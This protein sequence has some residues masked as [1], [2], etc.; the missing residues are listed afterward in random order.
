MTPRLPLL[1]LIMAG[2]ELSAT[3]HPA[4]GV[5]SLTNDKVTYERSKT[6]YAILKRGEVTAIIVDNRAHELP[7]QDLPSHRPGY[8][9]VSSLT[10]E[11]GKHNLFVPFFAG[12]NFEHIHDGTTANLKNKFE[13]RIFPM[14][15]RLVDEHTVELYQAPT[16]HWSLE[17]C[18]R[19]HLLADGTIEY[20]FECIPREAKY[21]RKFIGLFWAS[22]IQ[23]PESGSIHFLGQHLHGKPSLSPA[24]ITATSPAHGT[25]STHPP[26]A[27][28][29]A[30][31][32]IDRDFPLTLVNHPS[33]YYYREPFYFGVSGN[34]AFVQVFRSS[35]QIWF[36][37]SPSGG[38]HGNPAW[39]F[40]WFIRNPRVHTAYGFV[41][42]A[43]YL[44]F[45]SRE[46]VA[47]AME[48][49]LRAL[50]P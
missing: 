21:T 40:Q 49:H 11:K 28:R 50:N 43:A 5:T 15:L 31:P 39:D 47:A 13:P 46:Q 30:L 10:H 36:A 17:S 3:P 33:D 14:E 12:L 45:V 23:K 37:Q 24:W 27:G 16:G 18:G 38:G 8:N 44:P 35:D 26:E 29:L 19:Y 7:E 48:P 41:M 32:S 4:P 34:M 25:A 1:L 6:G 9:G 2:A 20:T 42:R 22:Y